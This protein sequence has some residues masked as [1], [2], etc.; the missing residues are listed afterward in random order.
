MVA[1]AIEALKR[2]DKLPR[3]AEMLIVDPLLEKF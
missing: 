1:S 3:S 2:R